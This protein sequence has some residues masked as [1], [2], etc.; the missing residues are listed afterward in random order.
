ILSH[1]HNLTVDCKQ[2]LDKI[3]TEKNSRDVVLKF[4]YVLKRSKNVSIMMDNYKLMWIVLFGAQMTLYTGAFDEVK[5][6]VNQKCPTI[7]SD[8][9]KDSY[10]CCAV[11]ALGENEPCGS[12][13]PARCGEGLIC[14]LSDK[15]LIFD[16]IV[17]PMET[18]CPMFGCSCKK[19]IK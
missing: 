11:C 15:D 9:E 8:C 16:D 14:S 4:Y 6:K 3:E 17:I 18:A 10:G 19:D 5:C 13:F 12:Q 2:Q 7:K 1:E